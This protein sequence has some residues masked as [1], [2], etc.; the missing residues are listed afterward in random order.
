M[1]ET[2]QQVQIVKDSFLIT[3]PIG[4]PR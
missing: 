2:D 4:L 1:A 3:N